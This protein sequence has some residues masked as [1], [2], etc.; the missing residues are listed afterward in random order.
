[1]LCGGPAHFLDSPVTNQFCDLSDAERLIL[2]IEP[3]P[4]VL[5]VRVL[6]EPMLPA[7]DNQC[8]QRTLKSTGDATNAVS[9]M[10]ERTFSKIGSLTLDT[11]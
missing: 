7:P 5:C 11:V 2:N 6:R 1:M 8:S 3:S 10:K 4:Y 9:S